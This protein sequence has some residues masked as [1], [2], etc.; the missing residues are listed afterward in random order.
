MRTRRLA[1]FVGIVVV[2]LALPH[3]TF[4]YVHRF[5]NEHPYWDRRRRAVEEERGLYQFPPLKTDQ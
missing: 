5:I 4:P 3:F 2:N 1:Q